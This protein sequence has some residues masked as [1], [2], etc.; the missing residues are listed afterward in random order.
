MV[1]VLM[2]NT[3]SYGGMDINFDDIPD[4]QHVLTD[5]GERSQVYVP[6]PFG[7]EMADELVLVVKPFLPS[8]LLQVIEERVKQLEKA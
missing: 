8:V 2:Y 3:Q 4:F 5:T 1:R 7:H 6:R